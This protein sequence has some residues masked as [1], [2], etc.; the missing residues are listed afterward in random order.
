M[1]NLQKIVLEKLLALLRENDNIL[2][3]RGGRGYGVGH[4]YQVKKIK[5]TLGDQSHLEEESEDDTNSDP[6]QISKAFK[7]KK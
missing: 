4:P 5:P 3:V 2:N 7:E 6:V 1:K